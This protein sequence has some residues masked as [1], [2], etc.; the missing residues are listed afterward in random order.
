[1][2][3]VKIAVLIPVDFEHAN[4]VLSGVKDVAY[5]RSW[6]IVPLHDTRNIGLQSLIATHSVQGIIGDLLS[7]RWVQSLHT[8]RPV[9]LVHTGEQSV[10]ETV[11][12]AGSDH[13]RA[14]ALAAS[15]FLSRH[16]RHL[17]FAG[18]GGQDASSRDKAAG[19]AGQAQE[20]G[21]A[22]TSFPPLC[23]TAPLDSWVKFVKDLPAPAAIFCQDDGVARRLITCCRRAGRTVPESLS[24]M[25]CGNSALDSFFAGIGISS[26]E[27]DDR[28]L[29]AEAARLIARALDDPG[30]SPEYTRIPPTGLVLRETTGAGNLDALVGRALDFMQSQLASPLS[31]ADI[32]RHVNASR[33]LLELRFRETLGR[34]PHE[35]LVRLRMAQARELLANPQLSI[36]TVAER[37]GYPERPHFYARFKQHH[38]G[39]PP[40]AWRHANGTSGARYDDE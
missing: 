16:Y 19:F 5:R 36:G 22:I 34:S 10:L 1:M 40:A 17:Y 31:V 32:A 30:A 8:D 2:N 11:S 13:R 4:A 3:A 14:G 9:A 39:L 7:D 15:H 38:G 20:A 21:L 37:C 35:E 23:L 27:T 6:D 26:I 12:C 18:L 24:L 33:R 28:R 25:G 29:G